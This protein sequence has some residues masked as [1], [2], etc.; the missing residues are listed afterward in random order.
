[1][2]WEADA[3]Q[4]TGGPMGE[5]NRQK[6]EIQTQTT[7][8][9][10]GTAGSQGRAQKQRRQRD[11]SGQ[12]S[13]AQSCPHKAMTKGTVTQACPKCTVLSERSSLSEL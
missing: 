6:P 8:Q 13:T 7:G 5:K 9:S 11:I 3:G 10:T 12:T 1:M 2:A 4:V